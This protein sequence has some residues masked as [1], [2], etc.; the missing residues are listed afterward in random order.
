MLQNATH[1]RKSTPW[2]WPPN[3]SDGDVFG[4]AHATQTASLQTL[5][6][7]PTPAVV[8]ETATIPSHCSLVAR[9]RI[10]CAC[11]R[12]VTVERPKVVWTRRLFDI[13]TST[14]ASRHS[15]MH[16]FNSSIYKIVVRKWCVFNMLTLKCAS[17]H[18][19]PQRRALF[20]I[21]TSKGD[22]NMLCFYHFDLN[23]YFA[24]QRRA[25]FQRRFWHFDVEM[26]FAP[27]RPEIDLSSS[28]MLPHPP[29]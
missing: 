21:S 13:L 27:Q 4:I 16:F 15:R 12:K 20:N 5:F 10:H 11:H 3:M 23:M 25:H 8:F 29:L 28:Q 9:C 2:P 17:R 24:P 19:A 22:P 14:C 26:C 18:S 1:L 7:I 6:K